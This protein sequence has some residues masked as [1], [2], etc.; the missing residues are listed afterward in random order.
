[1]SD[2]VVRM[3]VSGMDELIQ[4]FEDLARRYPDKA[5]DLL[6][7]DGRSLRKEIVKKARD[8]TDTP[9]Q[10]KMSLGKVG[11]YGIS[12][13][14]GYG[15]NQYVEITAKSPHFHLV[16]H[17]HELVS[18]SGNHIGFVPGKHYLEQ[19]TKEFTNDIPN[20]VSKMVD[21]LLKEEGLT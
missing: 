16:E 13:V 7:K 12:P 19:A 14:K 4:S 2:H 6:R 20:H 10:S 5:G 3:D 21:E 15:A 1:M 17:G 18:H 8:L 11:S 9:R